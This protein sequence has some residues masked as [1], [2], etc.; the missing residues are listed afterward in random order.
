[1]QGLLM[2]VKQGFETNE[3]RL[4]IIN[5]REEVS[6][7]ARTQLVVAMRLHAQHSSFRL[8]TSSNTPSVP[9]N[10]AHGSFANSDEEMHFL[11]CNFCLK[12]CLDEPAQFKTRL[13]FGRAHQ[14]ISTN[15]WLSFTHKEL[16]IM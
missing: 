6:F 16:G 1:M 11:S 2:K 12:K 13:Q 15:L 8:R 3:E 9:M 5:L 4:P 10:D 14:L 7:R